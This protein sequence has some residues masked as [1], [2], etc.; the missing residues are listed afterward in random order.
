MSLGQLCYEVLLG[1]GGY[2]R[3]GRDGMTAGMASSRCRV[4]APG[5]RGDL[6]ERLPGSA[7]RWTVVTGVSRSMVSPVLLEPASCHTAKYRTACCKL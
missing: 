4:L 7:V 3:T 6:L 1:L 2:S 5:Y